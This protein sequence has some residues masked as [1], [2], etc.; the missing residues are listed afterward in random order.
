MFND[1]QE[2]LISKDVLMEKVKELGKRISEDYKGK[3]LVVVCVLKGG[4]VFYADLIR[5]LSIPVEL[6]FIAVS[7]YGASTKSSG[8][9]KI[10]KDLDTNISGKHVLIIEDIIDTGL[11]LSHLKELLKT[12]GPLSVKICS[13]LDKPSR[14]KIEIDIEYKGLEIPDKFVVGYGLDYGGKYRNIPDVCVLKQ[15]I[16]SKGW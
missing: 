6:D 12:R 3:E 9:V 8:V 10:T 7:S 1:I 4:V 15:S 2:V 13:A 5:E 11:T 14:R 16:Y